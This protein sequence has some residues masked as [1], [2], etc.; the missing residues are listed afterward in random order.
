[1]PKISIIIPTYNRADSLQRALNSLW[2]QD[3][4]ADQFEVIVVDDGST[5][6][7]STLVGESARPVCYIRQSQAGPGVARNTGATAASS[8][9]LLFFDDD[10]VATPQLLTNHLK[11]HNAMPEPVSVL[12]YTPFD[13]ACVT[14]PVMA[15]HD[16]RWTNIFAAVRAAYQ[17][18]G[19]LP[20]N[21]FISLNLSVPRQE[22]ER[23]GPFYTGFD[24]AYEDTELGLRFAQAG[25]PHLFSEE[26]KAIHKPMLT[27]DSLTVR[28]ERFGYLSAQYYRHHPD[29]ML[30]NESMRVDY[31]L[32]KT[33][34]F[35]RRVLR[36]IVMNRL[37]IRLLM[38]IGQLSVVP[39]PIQ[40]ACLKRVALFSYAIGFQRGS[41]R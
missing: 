27:L 35:P 3:L 31:V 20:F 41:G 36:G 8:P 2:E 21:F 19:K 9:L 26:A 7:T 40:M 33:N 4:P 18:E 15:Y 6:H 5:D 39:V 17:R 10:V 37:G 11:V 29:N 38:G 22:F 16:R 14:S 25:I 12:G 30:M 23:I 32:G 13:P 24:A 34:S 28:Q 1:M